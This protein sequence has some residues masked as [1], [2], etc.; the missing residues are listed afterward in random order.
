VVLS[1]AVGYLGGLDETVA[2]AGATRENEDAAV[3]QEATPAHKPWY[4]RH[5]LH[6]W[7][8]TIGGVSLVGVLGLG[9]T[10]YFGWVSLTRSDLA[11]SEQR[12][13]QQIKD[14]KQPIVV[15]IGASHLD[16]TQN[17][18]TNVATK[19][20]RNPAEARIASE[21]APE[22]QRPSGFALLPKSNTSLTPELVSPPSRAIP[23][24]SV[25]NKEPRTIS[26]A[27]TSNETFWGI[28]MPS[29]GRDRVKIAMTGFDGVAQSYATYYLREHL[30]AVQYRSDEFDPTDVLRIF[31]SVSEGR[32]PNR[33]FVGV[34]V[35]LRYQVEGLQSPHEAPA[36]GINQGSECI[37]N[38]R[39][40]AMQ[41]AVSNAFLTLK[42]HLSSGTS[43]Q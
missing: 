22:A 30:G 29:E 16:I 33:C 13:G 39:T 10:V 27:L 34:I 6:R 35:T 40:A 23:D 8:F 31:A 14:S 7:I 15:Q 26:A 41:T 12:I 42:S 2:D 21:P 11:A 19:A 9:F 28:K 25:T 1:I 3:H 5:D 32:I 18:T 24:A 38:D 20:S 43:T 17:N 4:Q 37:T 36:S